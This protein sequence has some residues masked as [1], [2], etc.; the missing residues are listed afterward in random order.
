M[1]LLMEH[2]GKISRNCYDDPISNPNSKLQRRDPKKGQCKCAFNVLFRRSRLFSHN[3]DGTEQSLGFTFLEKTLK[4]RPDLPGWCQLHSQ[5]CFLSTQFQAQTCFGLAQGLYW[6]NWA[7]NW[8]FK[9][10]LGT[11]VSETKQ[12]SSKLPSTPSCL[13]PNNSTK[14]FIAFLSLG[15]GQNWP[16]WGPNGE[17]YCFKKAQ[18]TFNRWLKR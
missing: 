2:F 9:Y 14:C 16:N 12:L 17:S 5:L 13:T 15:G 8:K 6:E 1:L 3:S 7:A 18:M 11:L 10:V 4:T